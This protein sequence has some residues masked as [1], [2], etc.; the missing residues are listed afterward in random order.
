MLF[1]IAVVIRPRAPVAA[2]GDDP[3]L[4]AYKVWEREA[5]AK[6]KL[7]PLKLREAVYNFA[8]VQEFTHSGRMGLPIPQEPKRLSYVTETFNFLSFC[9]ARGD[10]W[11]QSQNV[12]TCWFNF[13]RTP[14]QTQEQ[15]RIRSL[16][17]YVMDRA[18]GNFHDK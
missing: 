3:G 6:V 14:N 7:L 16:G 8:L 9:K 15:A 10:D 2:A 1:Q 4:A 11:A 12:T 18:Q 17:A 5:V 13:L